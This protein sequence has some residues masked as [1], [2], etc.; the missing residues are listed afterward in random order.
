MRSRNCFFNISEFCF[1]VR[2]F[3]SGIY[4]VLKTLGTAYQF[5]CDRPPGDE[6]RFLLKECAKEVESHIGW[7]QE[8]AVSKYLITKLG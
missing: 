5:F 4:R 8:S 3:G 2:R 6:I 1:T 7:N